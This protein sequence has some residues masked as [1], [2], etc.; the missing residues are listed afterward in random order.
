MA[1]NDNKENGVK[2]YRSSIAGLSVVV[3][4]PLEG[5]AAPQTVRFTPYY[6]KTEMGEE[7]LHGYLETDNKVAID[8]LS[9]D[10]NVTEIDHDTFKKYTDVKNAKIRKA[11]L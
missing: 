5:Q 4:D 7:L 6:Y 9:N 11:G 3:G 8:K 10:S 1:G 2:H